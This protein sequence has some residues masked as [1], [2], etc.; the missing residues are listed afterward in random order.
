MRYIIIVII[1][2]KILNII[3]RNVYADYVIN[4][5]G[6]IIILSYSDKENVQTIIKVLDTKSFQPFFSFKLT[7]FYYQAFVGEI[8]GNAIIVGFLDAGVKAIYTIDIANGTIISKSIFIRK[9]VA[10]TSMAQ[11]YPDAILCKNWPRQYFWLN[12]CLY[13]GEILNEEI[14]IHSLTDRGSAKVIAV[15][16]IGGFHFTEFKLVEKDNKIAIYEYWFMI[17]DI[18][19]YEK[20]ELKNKIYMFAFEEG[21]KNPKCKIFD[22]DRIIGNKRTICKIS[23]EHIIL[24]EDNEKDPNAS[25]MLWILNDNA[26][27][28]KETKIPFSL[29]ALVVDDEEKMMIGIKREIVINEYD[30]LFEPNKFKKKTAGGLV[31]VNLESG[32]IVK[33]IDLPSDYVE[34]AI[35]CRNNILVATTRGNLEIWPIDSSQ[36]NHRM[37]K[38][39]W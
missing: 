5:K 21:D 37:I 33:R 27:L 19:R 13:W 17:T 12:K 2:I 36:E 8:N 32:E 1:V 16:N 38:I 39:E 22:V 14:L 9:L 6:Q 11:S 28:Q 18:I 35:I 34:D 31:V 20:P 25:C 3:E 10:E 26:Q 4:K 24:Y 15:P 30:W 23:N 7:G 29:R